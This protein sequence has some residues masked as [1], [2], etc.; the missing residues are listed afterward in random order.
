MREK[1]LQCDDVVLWPENTVLITGIP[2]YVALKK[3]GF[4]INSKH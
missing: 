2:C 3:N 4:R 1:K